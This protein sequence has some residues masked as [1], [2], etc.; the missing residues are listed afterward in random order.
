MPASDALARFDPDRTHTQI[1][2]RFTCTA[3]H[4]HGHPR[5]QVRMSITDFYRQCGEKGLGVGK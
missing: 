1:A 2:N 4:A 5:I 3:R